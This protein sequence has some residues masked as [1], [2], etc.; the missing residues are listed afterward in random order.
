MIWWLEK[1]RN[2]LQAMEIIM[3]ETDCLYCEIRKS[4]AEYQF[5]RA[6]FATSKK[7]KPNPSMSLRGRNEPMLIVQVLE[8]VSGIKGVTLNKLAEVNPERYEGVSL[9]YRVEKGKYGE[10]ARW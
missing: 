3:L 10:E 9:R 6:Q 8:E 1:K 2:K 4:H 5:V 7:E